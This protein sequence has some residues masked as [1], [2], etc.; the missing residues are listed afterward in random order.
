MATKKPSDWYVQG[1]S[2]DEL[3][4][5]GSD[6]NRYQQMGEDKLRQVVNRLASAANKRARRM[7]KAGENSPALQ[8]L[9]DSGGPISTKDKTLEE[10]QFEF[11]R[12]KDYMEDKTSSLVFWQ[13]V[14]NTSTYESFGRPSQ[15]VSP[16]QTPQPNTPPFMGSTNRDKYAEEGEE[17]YKTVGDLWEQVDKLINQDKKYFDRAFRYVVYDDME[18]GYL[19]NIEKGI[20][21]EQVRDMVASRLEELYNSWS[22]QIGE[23]QAHGVGSSFEY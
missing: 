13:Q 10:L 19:S 16:V 5:L 9:K 8:R 15:A 17:Y 6:F 21:L 7:E 22:D 18:R 1:K 20:T 12:V 3:L 2:I 14:K 11:L 4:K 23:A